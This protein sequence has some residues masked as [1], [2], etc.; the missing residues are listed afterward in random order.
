MKRIA[1]AEKMAKSEK[2]LDEIKAEII[3]FFTANKTNI[4]VIKPV[5]ELCRESG[6]SN[7]NEI[8]DIDIAEKVLAACK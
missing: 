2:K 1:E 4:S 6:F 7:P 8:D 5:L 3:E